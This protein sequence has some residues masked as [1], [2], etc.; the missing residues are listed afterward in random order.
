MTNTKWELNWPKNCTT[1]SEVIA[2]VYKIF[3]FGLDFPVDLNALN[4]QSQ[5]RRFV[6]SM[7]VDVREDWEV[8]FGLFS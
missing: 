4:S 5:R 1:Y 8:I 2:Y 6:G 3:R 7:K